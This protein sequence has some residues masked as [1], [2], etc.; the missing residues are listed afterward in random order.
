MK[1][2]I[3]IL[4]SL[5]MGLTSVS[6]Q[7]QNDLPYKP[8]KWFNNDTIQYLD[9]N[10]NIRH[11]QYE[12]KKVAD[13]IKDIELPIV[14]VTE[15]VSLIDTPTKFISVI[16]SLTLGI[17]EI[18]SIY[19]YY[20]VIAFSNVIPFDDF[21]K[22]AETIREE[23]R[24]ITHWTP[25]LYELLKDVEIKT[26]FTNSKLI[27]ARRKIFENNNPNYREE[28]KIQKEKETKQWQLKNHIEK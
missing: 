27:E 14:Y 2:I 10:F 28:L 13:F 5:V 18:D 21:K 9:Y 17:R 20:V 1:Q 7:A 26:I 25:P 19:D 6:L 23:N 24:V 15:L 11:A 3:F 22:A 16:G 4:A 12:G 8:L